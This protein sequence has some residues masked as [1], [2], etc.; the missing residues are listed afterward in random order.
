MI[1][2]QLLWMVGTLAQAPDLTN[3]P[4]EGLAQLERRY[5]EF[6]QKNQFNLD[7]PV[8]KPNKLQKVSE[9]VRAGKMNPY[10]YQHLTQTTAAAYY[11]AVA[12]ADT[13]NLLKRTHE[14]GSFGVQSFRVGKVNVSRDLL[15]SIS[16]M[17]FLHKAFLYRPGGLNS[18]KVLDVGGGYGRL[19]KR[20]HDCW[21]DS[22][23]HLTDGLAVSTLT[24]RK[25]LGAYGMAKAVVPLH[26]LDAFLASNHVDLLINTHSFPE[27]NEKD[28]RFWLSRAAKH[29]IEYLFIAPNGFLTPMPLLRTNSHVSITDMLWGLGYRLVLW[30]NF[31][32]SSLGLCWAGGRQDGEPKRLTALAHSKCERPFFTSDEMDSFA[33][34]FYL[35]KRLSSVEAADARAE[36]RS[37]RGAPAQ[38]PPAARRGRGFAA[39]RY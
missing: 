37:A 8:W 29:K 16:E 32:V 17:L 27:M 36:V 15:D 13:I 38:R 11:H 35:F 24:A 6:Y 20:W 31:Y 30:E 9:Q 3:E 39:R 4:P 23:Y 22:T 14:D 18:L 12:D 25:Y 19:A 10:V 5:A 34:P 28:V 7:A 1:V 21:P 2:G 33:V 26:K